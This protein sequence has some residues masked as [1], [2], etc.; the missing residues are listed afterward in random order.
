MN[1][2]W[3]GVWVTANGS[4]VVISCRGWCYWHGKIEGDATDRTLFWADNGESFE[5]PGLNLRERVGVLNAQD[6]H[7]AVPEI[8]RDHP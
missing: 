2:N 1:P 7:V 5:S 4:T 3:E 6:D 8:R